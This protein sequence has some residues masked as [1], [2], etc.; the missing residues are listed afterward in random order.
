MFHDENQIFYKDN[1]EKI[2]AGILLTSGI[3]IGMSFTVLFMHRKKKVNG[4]AV[5][6]SVKEMFLTDGPIEG[7]WI[8]LYPVPLTRFSAE[9]KVYYGGISRKENDQLIQYEFIADAYTGTIL[10]IYKL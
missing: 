2:L 4:E 8:E 3:V 5:L 10:D 1:K 6:E 9:T 7:S